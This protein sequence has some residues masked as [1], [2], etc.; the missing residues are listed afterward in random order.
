MDIIDVVATALVVAVEDVGAG[1]VHGSLDRLYR[2][3]GTLASDRRAV[4]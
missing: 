2:G 3:A 1:Y 4:L